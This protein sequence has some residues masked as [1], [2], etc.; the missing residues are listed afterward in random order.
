MLHL[1]ALTT[2]VAGS[3]LII[4]PSLWPVFESGSPY[5]G[6]GSAIK[7]FAHQVGA[8]LGP[9]ILLVA[10]GAMIFQAV[11]AN[12]MAPALAPAPVAVADPVP[13]ALLTSAQ[14]ATPA[15]P[16]ARTVFHRSRRRPRVTPPQRRRPPRATRRA[17]P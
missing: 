9:G 4:G 1:A 13:S 14:A 5:G 6:A 3:W 16:P 15:E 11:S 8:N 17:T 12:R 2:F 7:S 10:L